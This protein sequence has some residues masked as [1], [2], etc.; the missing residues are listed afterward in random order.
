[1]KRQKQ[2]NWD[3]E[4]YTLEREFEDVTSLVRNLKSTPPSVPNHLDRAIRQ[5]LQ[6]KPGHEL[7]LICLMGPS[8][9]LAMGATLLF[10]IGIMFV[11]SLEQQAMLNLE[12]KLNDSSISISKQ[13]NPRDL[14]NRSGRLYSW[15]RLTFIV[16][17]SGK[18]QNISVLE[19]C[20][21]VEPGICRD[22]RRIDELAIQQIRSRRYLRSGQMEKIVFIPAKQ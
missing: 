6:R 1:M 15:A 16:T 7:P 19:R 21:K 22:D 8:L 5:R 12:S 11:L 17:S 10:G 9:Q 20:F 3:Q 2:P 4:D 13:V 18:A 14:L